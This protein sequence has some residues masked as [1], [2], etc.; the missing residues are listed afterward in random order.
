MLGTLTVMGQ[1]LPNWAKEDARTQGGGWVWF[2]GKFIHSDRTVATAMAI[3]ASV[4][5]LMSECGV[6]H[7]ETKFIEKFARQDSK[8]NWQVVL[9]A[10][11][12][13]KHC[14]QGKYADLKTKRALANPMLMDKYFAYRQFQESKKLDTNVC[15]RSNTLGCLEVA[16]AEWQTKNYIKAAVYAKRACDFGD[17]YTCGFYGTV[18]WDMGQVGQ[19]RA[20]YGMACN[21]G[22]KKY[23]GFR[24]ELNKQLASN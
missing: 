13:D 24:G 14:S 16:D 17:A 12:K 5:Y 7:K 9:R 22:E 11:I 18:L 15:N 20:Y 2:P 21:A 10:A 19:A 8:G 6:P 23:C 3:G 4:E 1:E